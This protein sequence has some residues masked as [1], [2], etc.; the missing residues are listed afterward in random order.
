MDPLFATRQW[1]CAAC[2]KDIGKYEGKLG[3]FKPWSVFPCRELSPERSGGYGYLSYIDKVSYR[4]GI[5]VDDSS[6]ERLNQTG[7]SFRRLGE[8]EKELSPSPNTSRE[9]KMNSTATSFMN[10]FGDHAEDYPR[11]K[12]EYFKN[13]EDKEKDKESSK[14]DSQTEGKPTEKDEPEDRKGLSSV[15]KTQRTFRVKEAREKRL[16]NTT[17]ELKKEPAKLEEEPQRQ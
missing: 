1:M 9:K 8:A 7:H 3:K 2:T 4:K 13:P 12:G 15:R 16:D 17:T 14:V 11:L 5:S 6:I 10:A